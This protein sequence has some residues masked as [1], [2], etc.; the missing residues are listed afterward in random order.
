MRSSRELGG[1]ATGASVTELSCKAKACSCVGRVR[2][3]R[4]HGGCGAMLDGQSEVISM[5][6]QIEIGVTPGMELRGAP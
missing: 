5:T 3:D 2:D 1:G 6:T 4:G